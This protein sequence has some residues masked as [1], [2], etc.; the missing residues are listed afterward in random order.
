[1]LRLLIVMVLLLGAQAMS[2]ATEDDTAPAVEASGTATIQVDPD[3]I[4]WTLRLSDS[5]LVL[6]SATQRNAEK[7]TRV[8]ELLR[9]RLDIEAREIQTGQL[10]IDKKYKSSGEFDGWRVERVISVTQREIGR[11]DEFLE[12]LVDQAEIETSYAFDTSRR[13]ELRFEARKQAV[14][15]ARRKAE[16]MVAAVGR[17]CLPGDIAPSGNGGPTRYRD[18]QFTSAV[19][20]PLRI[21][22]GAPRA[23][24]M[25]TPNMWS[26]AVSVAGAMAPDADAVQGTLA[27]GAISITES[28]TVTFA[29][30]H[31]RLLAEERP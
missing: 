31:R 11:F 2:S 23:T 18:S 30:V 6:K 20:L 7:M 21:V 24:Y 25:G 16:D 12:T 8:L 4:R 14:Q 5:D 28:V 9:D 29:L 3:L 26:N 13:Q 15:V 27:P 22:E 1:M 19:G 17:S 10:N